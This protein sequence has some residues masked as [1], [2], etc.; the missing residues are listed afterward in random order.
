MK[1]KILIPIFLIFFILIVPCFALT[2]TLNGN[3]DK[4]QNSTYP[5]FSAQTNSTYISNQQAN[6]TVN[7]PIIINNATGG[8]FGARIYLNY[9]YGQK[10]N[11]Y[12][13]DGSMQFYYLIDVYNGNEHLYSIFNMKRTDNFMGS[14]ASLNLGLLQ[15]SVSST[16]LGLTGGDLPVLPIV[17]YGKIYTANTSYTIQ[18][19]RQDSTH[20]SIMYTQ[21]LL[22][23]GGGF[24]NRNLMMYNENYTN[25]A[26]FW[27]NA[28][29]KLYIGFQGSGAFNFTFTDLKVVENPET[30]NIGD[31]NLLIPQGNTI[32]IINYLPEP[33]KTI[34]LFIIGFVNIII[35]LLSLA[36]QG[37]GYVLPYT[38]WILILYLIDAC[39]TSYQQKSFTPIGTALTTL[40]TLAITTFNVLITIAQFLWSMISSVVNLLGGLGSLLGFIFI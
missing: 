27:D 23:Q 25:S 35:G 7:D 19:Q 29:A 1:L 33:L 30:I 5:N 22:T 31:T 10:I 6:Y 28:T 13:L 2:L 4:W 21:L 36:V 15:T 20:T 8:L 34:A 24:M 32:N 18:F 12:D 39:Y 26:N 3:T 9:L 17:S 11:W 40:Y 37:I 38:P 14:S 16:S